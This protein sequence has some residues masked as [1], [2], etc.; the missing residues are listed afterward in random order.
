LTR[1]QL[2]IFLQTLVKSIVIK[3]MHLGL[4]CWFMV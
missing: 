4:K 1:L 3:S 2:I